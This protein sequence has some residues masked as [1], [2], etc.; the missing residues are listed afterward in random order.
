MLGGARDSALK[1]VI[2]VSLA[3][4]VVVAAS[5]GCT[6]TNRPSARGSTCRPRR[7]TEGIETSYMLLS[8]PRRHRMDSDDFVACHSFGVAREKRRHFSR[9]GL[10]SWVRLRRQPICRKSPAGCDRKDRE[11][12]H[13][14][15]PFFA[16][17]AAKQKVPSHDRV[18]SVGN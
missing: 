9:S 7:R 6:G 17:R 2:L 14:S 15:P 1:K 13:R 3:V 12:D 16:I 8:K 4:P 18:G 10:C 11:I 5:N